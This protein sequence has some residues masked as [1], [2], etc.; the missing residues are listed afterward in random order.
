[1][2]THRRTDDLLEAIPRPDA[3]TIAR[4]HARLV[5][6]A[7]NEGVLDLGYRAVDSPIG[8]LLLVATQQGIVRIAFEREGHHVVLEQLAASIS[9]RILHGT[10]RLD[11]AAAQLDEYFA[12]RRREFDLSLDLQLARGFRRRVLDHLRDLRY[13]TTAT[14]STIASAAGSPTAVRAVGTA[15]A[16][17]PLPIVIPCHRVVRRDG[18]IGQYLGGTDTKRALLEMESTR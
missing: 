8:R 7:E 9:P 6:D 18:T 3:P 16:T 12:G 2:G 11:A 17:N 5:A 10:S 14:Y 15:C 13:G 4:L 1:M